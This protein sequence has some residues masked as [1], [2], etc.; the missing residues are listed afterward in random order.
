MNILTLTQTSQR[1]ANQ[2]TNGVTVFQ[3]DSENGII[4]VVCEKWNDKQQCFNIYSG[5]EKVGA[6][7][8]YPKAIGMAIIYLH[9]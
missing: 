7:T 6:T 2:F 1:H 3:A 9:N 4:R 5:A 8:N